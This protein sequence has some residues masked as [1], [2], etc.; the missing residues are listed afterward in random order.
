M[1]EARKYQFLDSTGEPV[2]PERVLKQT[3]DQ[4]WSR[5]SEE[6]MGDI[7]MLIERIAEVIHQEYTVQLRDRREE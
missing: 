7:P 5:A 4:V 3:M 1:D 6:E 2:D